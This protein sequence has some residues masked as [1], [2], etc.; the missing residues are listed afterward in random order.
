MN[1]LKEELKLEDSFT[2]ESF[3]GDNKSWNEEISHLKSFAGNLLPKLFVDHKGPKLVDNKINANPVIIRFLKRD[4]RINNKLN[5]NEHANKHESSLKRRNVEKHG[6]ENVTIHNCDHCQ[7]TCS[8]KKYFNQHRSEIHGDVSNK[9]TKVYKISVLSYKCENC[10]YSSSSLSSLNR[11]KNKS[12]SELISHQTLYKCKKCQYTC[13]RNYNLT[14][15]YKTAKHNLEESF[16]NSTEYKFKCNECVRKFKQVK[17]LN[18]HVKDVHRRLKIFYCDK[19]K[20]T[21]S[22]PIRLKD[23]VKAVHE[24]IRDY[25]CDL[26]NYATYQKSNLNVHLKRIHKIVHAKTKSFKCDKCSYSSVVKRNLISHKYKTHGDV[27]QPIERYKC[28]LC[29]NNSES[30]DKEYSTK[31]NLRRHIKKMHTKP[32]DLICNQPKGKYKCDL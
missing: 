27:S 24:G 1:A 5:A 26:C 19:C 13:T 9:R 15:H 17:L 10:N 12:H 16:F 4:I 31:S 14:K 18:R 7:Y 28:D 25:S 22:H 20:Y 3:N 8:L 21:A 32:K 30:T 23:H 29:K 2:D 11:H 6:K